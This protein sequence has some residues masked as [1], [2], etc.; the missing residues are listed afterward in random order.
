MACGEKDVRTVMDRT[1]NQYH[2]VLIIILISLIVA[3]GISVFFSHGHGPEIPS[4]DHNFLEQSDGTGMS[5][6]ESGSWIVRILWFDDQNRTYSFQDY[7]SDNK[8]DP[9]TYTF[10]GDPPAGSHAAMIR[11]L[12]WDG[13][14]E[15]TIGSR[16]ILDQEAVTS[17][18]NR[19]SL[20]ASINPALVP[21]PI[22]TDTP[23][24]AQTPAPGMLMPQSGRVCRNADGSYTA[25]FGYQSRHE[26]PVALSVGDQ[27]TFFPGD[28]D[29]G[30]PALFMPG[31]HHDVFSIT[32]PADATNQ[33]W[34]LMNKQVSVGTVPEVNTSITLEPTSGYAPLEVRI[35]QRS[36]GG[37]VDNPL[38]GSWNL[39]DGTITANTNSFSHRYESPGTYQITHVVSNACNQASDSGIIEVYGAS[40]TWQPEPD[41][42]AIIR[43]TDTS[44][45]DPSVW[46]W[47]FGDGYSSWEQ[48]PVHT[49]IRPG[50]YNAG[51]T[52]SGRHGKG[53]IVHTIKIPD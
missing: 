41:N 2:F 20:M 17:I 52:L 39:G 48:H 19:Y 14:T 9:E 11:F 23:G 28:A 33:V 12:S 21:S 36:T 25:W 8:P 29:R 24:P 40:Y 49:Y 45:G 44:G 50:S 5:S 47:D 27:N 43:F 37:V 1:D 18:L 30:Q 26:S 3:A 7:S 35:S 6:N 34:S 31:I 15:R 16:Y 4:G 51:L 10:T 42:P 46:F 53:T 32:Y 22:M 13:N 38:S